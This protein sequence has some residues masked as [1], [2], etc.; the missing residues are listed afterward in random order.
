MSRS[1]IAAMTRARIV[2]ATPHQTDGAARVDARK[3]AMAES[4]SS[5]LEAELLPRRSMTPQAEAWIA[6]FMH[7]EAVYNPRLPA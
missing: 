7:K 1:P 5:P 3:Y 6:G 4:L 2:C